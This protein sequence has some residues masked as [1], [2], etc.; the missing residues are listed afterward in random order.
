METHNTCM[1]RTTAEWLT[2]TAAYTAQEVPI[3]GGHVF[4]PFTIIVPLQRPQWP[5]SRAGLLNG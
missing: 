1:V 5:I 2:H 3:L 4:L